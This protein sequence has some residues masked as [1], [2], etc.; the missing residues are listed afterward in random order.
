MFKEGHVYRFQDEDYMRLYST[1]DNSIAAIIGENFFEV[2]STDTNGNILSMVVIGMRD[3]IITAGDG[4]RYIINSAHID[5]FV[6]GGG[7]GKPQE[8]PAVNFKHY[9]IV[10]GMNVQLVSHSYEEIATEA[11][12]MKEEYPI[13]T[14][15]IY[16]RIGVVSIEPTAVIK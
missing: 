6:D 1:F 9:A 2:L 12:K 7:R 11:K 14:V 5:Y 10:K 8:E 3:G 15:E 13:S 16:E 4:D